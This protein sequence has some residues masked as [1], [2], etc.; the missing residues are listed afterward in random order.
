MEAVNAI[1]EVE[2]TFDGLQRNKQ[3]AVT[4]TIDVNPTILI[5]TLNVN[6]LNISIKR[7]KLSDYTKRNSSW[8]LSIR[9]SL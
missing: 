9:N 8:R 7:E 1:T 5:T 2:N 6:D 4:N 3:K